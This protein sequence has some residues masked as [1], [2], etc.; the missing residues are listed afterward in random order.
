MG[1]FKKHKF[2]VDAYKE[3]NEDTKPTLKP[4]FTYTCVTLACM[5]LKALSLGYSRYQDYYTTR[6]CNT[7]FDYV[8]YPSDLEHLLEPMNW[9]KF[10][11]KSR[12]TPL[13]IKIYD[14]TQG[15]KIV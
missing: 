9:H 1:F 11:P 3:S 2:Y 4:R 7:I 12:L 8:Q 13:P 5:Y 6:S 15:G 14:I 10:V